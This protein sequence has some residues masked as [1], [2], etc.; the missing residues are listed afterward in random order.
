MKTF[1][2]WFD[3][4][5][6]INMIFTGVIVM[7]FIYSGFFSPQEDHYP[8]KCV[9]KEILGKP[10]PSCGLSHSFSE[11]V[12]GNFEKAREWNPNGFLIFF[13]FLI[14]LFQRILVSF[15]YARKL[16]PVRWIIII[17]ITVSVIMLL[18][19]FRYLIVFLFTYS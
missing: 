6:R 1:P 17:D 16:I 14:Q 5:H 7:I 18:Y 4:Y 8:V 15:V 10:C 11:I 3:A 19:C 9:H 2:C 12:R 13:F